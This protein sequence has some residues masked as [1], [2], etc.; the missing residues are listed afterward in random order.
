[1]PEAY[2]VSYDYDMA[3]KKLKLWTSLTSQLQRLCFGLFWSYGE[4]RVAGCGCST[5]VSMNSLYCD[6]D[7]FSRNVC[8]VAMTSICAVHRVV[9]KGEARKSYGHAMSPVG[10]LCQKR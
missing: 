7:F 8:V 6:L 10:D 3:R 1:M 2:A 9:A 4:L 5:G